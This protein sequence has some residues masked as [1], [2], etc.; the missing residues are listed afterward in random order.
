MVT[1]VSEKNIFIILSISIILFFVIFAFCS[2]RV[3]CADDVPD[4]T[5]E[6]DPYSLRTG[7]IL[8]VG[9]RQAFGW[10]VTGWSGS[11]WSHV[12][13]VWVDP[14]NG[15]IFV[16]EAA[17]YGGNYKGVIKIPISRWTR[18]N[19]KSYL[20]LSRLRG[21]CPDSKAL[22]EA[23][24]KRKSY[25]KLE[26]YNWRW[27]RLLYTTP[28][29]EET[30]SNYTCY[31]LVIT[32]LQDAGIMRKIN[33]CSSYFPLHITHGRIELEPGYRLLPP[34]LLDV[35]KFNKIRDIEEESS[36]NSKGIMGWVSGNR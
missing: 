11:I 26:S 22:I 34:L 25:A 24:E 31:E 9:Y 21:R 30:R 5:V 6:F 3:T 19:R 4:I 20:G 1:D 27:Y 13:I 17:N 8:S 14:D 28:Y 18:I 33:A 7:D 36:T 10:F 23:F 16:L 2:L 29:F 32:M 15:E 12:G 35:T